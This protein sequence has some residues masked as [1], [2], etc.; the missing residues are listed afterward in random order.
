M[1]GN[2]GE[3]E[4]T[5]F[6]EADDTSAVDSLE[7]EPSSTDEIPD[8]GGDTMIDVS[9]ELNVE[10]LVAKIEA[11]DPDE[12]AHKREVRKRLEELREQRDNDLD[13]TFNFNLDD[14]T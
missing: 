3:Q 14:D 12:A 6:D 1:I 11:T 13:S 5:D 7:A 9:A 10:E 8:I 4:D 2:N